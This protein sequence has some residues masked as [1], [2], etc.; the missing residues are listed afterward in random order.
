MKTFLD[1][2]DRAEVMGRIT[3][4]QPDT[5]RRWGRM[6]PNQAICHLT[7]AFSMCLG[8]RPVKERSNLFTRTAMRFVGLSTPMPWPR[9]VKTTPEADQEK[10]GTPPTEFSTDLAA[11]EKVAGEFVERL[12]PEA[13]RHPIFGL[14]TEV[15]WGRWAYRHLDH[16]ARQFGL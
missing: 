16:H 15:E 1:P 7:D 4:I 11:L 2:R 6:T 5:P 14:L 13:M 9:G 8:D 10:Q 3:S 12:D